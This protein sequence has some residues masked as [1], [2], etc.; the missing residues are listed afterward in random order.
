MDPAASK[1][2]T[3]I[4]GLMASGDRSAPERLL[5]LLYDELRAMAAS[6]LRHERPGHT[7][8]PTALVHEAYLRLVDQTRVQW[9]SKAH[10]MAVAA[11]AMRRIV[12]DHARAHHAAKRG[13]DAQRLTISD[14]LAESAEPP[15]DLLDLDEALRDLEALE[16]RQARVVELRFF[17]GLGVPETAEALGVGEK[18]VKNDWR[19]ARAWLQERL[20]R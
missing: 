6:R 13:G 17:A 10:F 11:Q 4:L 14:S 20:Q 7:L 3:E 19:F 9:Q 8:Q 12:I 2:A 18:T 5:R 16:P 15:L 1:S